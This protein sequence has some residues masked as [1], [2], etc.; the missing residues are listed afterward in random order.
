MSIKTPSMTGNLSAIKP[1]FKNVA[2]V[3]LT[4]TSQQSLV[5]ASEA[6]RIACD[7][8]AHFKIGKNPVATVNDP[9]IFAGDSEIYACERTDK[10][11]LI[12]KTG[13]N[14]GYAWVHGLEEA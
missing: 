13:Q 8:D 1:R 5:I 12:K 14:D 4:D 6:V 11:A 9:V 10:I 3:A 2:P 7:V